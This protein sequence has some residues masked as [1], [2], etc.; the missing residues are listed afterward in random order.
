[1]RSDSLFPVVAVIPSLNP[2]DK[3]PKTVDGLFQAGFT[4]VL[5]VDDGSRSDCQP[6]FD[7]LG[8]KAG[9]TVL[10]HEVNCGKGRAL[11]TAF[12]YYLERF[13]TRV[14]FG[15]VTADADGQHLPE[16]IY[17]T[18]RRICTPPHRQSTLFVCASGAHTCFGN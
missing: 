10:H 5:L 14:Y 9:C 6:I 16:D 15:V 8:K 12:S 7:E 1:M 2:D 18:A 4:D 3:L 11:K 17:Q 13:D